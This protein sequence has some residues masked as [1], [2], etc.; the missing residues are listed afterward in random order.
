M[1]RLLTA[2][3]A[4]SMTLSLAACAGSSSGGAASSAD[5]QTAAP[6]NTGGAQEQQPAG[7]ES[8]GGEYETITLKAAVAATEIEIPAQN[9]QAFADYIYEATGGAVSIQIYFGATLASSAEEL[10]LVSSGSVDMALNFQHLMYADQLPLMNF[11][12][13]IRGGADDII[14]YANAIIFEDPETSALINDELVANNIKVMYATYS[15]SCAFVGVNEFSSIADLKGKKMGNMNSVQFTAIG[16]TAITAM[17]PDVYESLSRGICD[18]SQL[19]L[20]GIYAL[21]W[22]EVA[23][24][25]MLDGTSAFGNL[26]IINLDTWNSLSD[27]VKAVFEDAAAYI[28]DLSMTTVDDR[29]KEWIAEMEAAGAVVSSFSEEDQKIWET[30]LIRANIETSMSIA[31][32]QGIVDKMTIVQNKVTELTGVSI[33]P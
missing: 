27:D 5:T 1:K 2:L 14:G 16:M 3:L 7:T 28:S 31:R 10:D 12:G 32:D 26:G 33:E 17:P 22:Y 13:F 29:Q 6:A 4:L 19:A 8:G 15:G 30:A 20:D 11:P 25:V 21:K 9:A 24:Y 18:Y 23:P